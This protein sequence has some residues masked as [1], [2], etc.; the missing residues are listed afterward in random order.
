MGEK[1]LEHVGFQGKFRSPR[2]VERCLSS[3]IG[4]SKVA[5]D[6]LTGIAKEYLYNVGRT[7]RFLT[8]KYSWTMTAEVLFTTL[9]AISLNVNKKSSSIPCLRAELREYKISN[10][11][12][13]MMSG[14]MVLV[15]ASLRGNL[16]A[17]IASL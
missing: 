11:I 15:W 14:G 5:L 7:I 9:E 3:A 4:A 12:S 6:V 10:V 16:S 1:V 2:S 17:L 8:D 13:Q